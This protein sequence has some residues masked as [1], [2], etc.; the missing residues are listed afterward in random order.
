VPAAAAGTLAV[1]CLA[2]V[3]GLAAACFTKVFGVAFLGE[4][5]APGAE[6]AREAPASLTASLLALAAACGALGLMGSRAA[7]W[8]APLAA[9]LAGSPWTGEA[10]LEPAAGALTKVFFAA[11]AVVA[12]AGLLAVVRALLLRRRAVK[13][14]PTWDCGYSAPSPRMQYSSSSFAQPLLAVFRGLVPV[15]KKAED[16]QGLFPSRASVSTESPDALEGGVYRPAFRALGW[17]IAR[18]RLLQHGRLQLYVLYIAAA[19]VVLLVWK[20]R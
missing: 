17:V 20:L 5:R 18:L 13:S 4:P 9:R 10:L 15:R 8:V 16:V 3:S 12:A 2:L 14:A 1:A 7:R 19:L 11:A 6:A